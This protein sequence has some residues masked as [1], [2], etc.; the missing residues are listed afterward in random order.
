MDQN[1]KVGRQV[2]ELFKQDIKTLERQSSK[3]NQLKW[4]NN[5]TWYK[6]DYTGYEGIVEYIVSNLLTKSSLNKSELCIYQTEE[7][8]YRNKIFLGCKSDNFLPKGWQLITL[9]R[10]FKNHYNESFMKNVFSITSYE[11]RLQFLVTQVSRIT[12]LKDFGI[13]MSKLLT[14][15]AFFLNEDRHM[16]N[17]AVMMDHLNQYHYCP[18]FD[19]GASLLSDT[20]MDYPMGEDIYTLIKEVESKTFCRNFD[21]Q[22]D[23]VE[24][25][26]GQYIKFEF[27][28]TDIKELLN[29]E[30]YY[31]SV[32][33]NR[34]TDILFY[35]FQ[36]YNYLF[37]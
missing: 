23:I 24:K 25:L 10:L 37:V 31:D 32:I 5:E 18:I 17:I 28:K 7:I 14:I 33:K 1:R 27:S 2:I 30:P 34:I 36:K 26:Y 16:H 15:D 21:D 29:K 8:L 11:E 6:A 12:G 22:L 3:G 35:Q 20:T 13:Y 9:E 4:F 19:N